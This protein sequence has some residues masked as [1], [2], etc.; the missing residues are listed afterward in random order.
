VIS[1]DLDFPRL[2]ALLGAARS[3]LILRRG[4]NVSQVDIQF[5]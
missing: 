2:L 3:G 1:P 4:G 5:A